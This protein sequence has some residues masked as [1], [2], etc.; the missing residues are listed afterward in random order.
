MRRKILLVF[1]STYLL[2]GLY[3]KNDTILSISF[4]NDS[5]K[6]NAEY[7]WYPGNIVGA[8][9]FLLNVLHGLLL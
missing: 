1:L 3:A 8:M 4:I 2:N 7:V 5:L 9:L 6:I